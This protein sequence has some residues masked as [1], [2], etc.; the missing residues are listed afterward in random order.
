MIR[1]PSAETYSI[2]SVKPCVRTSTDSGHFC[3]PGS[4]QLSAD[5][6]EKVENAASASGKA[7]RSLT[8]AGGALSNYVA[9]PLNESVQV[10][11]V[12][13]IPKNVKRTSGS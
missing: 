10:K 13:H 2:G 6:V 7:S 5:I 8:S 4:S 12:P 9:R 1:L 11:A 3:R